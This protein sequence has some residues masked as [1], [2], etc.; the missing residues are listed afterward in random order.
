MTFRSRVRLAT[1]YN[2]TAVPISV[3]CAVLETIVTNIIMILYNA[4][5]EKCVTSI[6]SI[7]CMKRN[8]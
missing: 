8:H 4:T 3:V 6:D 7:L 5:F 1:T 2:N